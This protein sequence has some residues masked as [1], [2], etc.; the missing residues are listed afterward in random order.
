MQLK[1]HHPHAGKLVGQDPG[2]D[3]GAQ[4]WD[5]QPALVSTAARMRA[6]AAVTSRDAAIR[7]NKTSMS[8]ASCTRQTSR[9]EARCLKGQKDASD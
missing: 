1:A 3:N 5:V 8:V 9:V 7:S 4:L 2:I 6:D